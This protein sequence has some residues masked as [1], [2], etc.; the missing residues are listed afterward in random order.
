MNIKIFGCRFNKFCAQKWLNYLNK[1]DNYILIAS[2]AVTDNAKKKF[3]KEVKQQIKNW[4]KIYLTWCGAFY[5]NG[6][7]DNNWFYDT[8]KCLSDYK[9][10]ITL[11][12][13]FPENTNI[14][15]FDKKLYTKWFVIV[16][17]GC[18]NNCTFCITTK[19]RWNHK[20]RKIKDVINDI[21]KLY[22]LW[23]KEI[24]LT[25]I[26]LASWW[27]KTTHDYP[28]DIFPIYLKDILKNTDVPRIR[29]SSIWPEFITDNRFKIFENK[30]I[31]PYFHLSIQS[32]SD[33][34][35]KL[36]WRHYNKKLILD[37]LK[38]FYNLNKSVP[39]NIW[40]DII[41]W[42]PWE[43]DNDFKQT[44]EIASYITK[45]HVFSFS[46][47]KIWDTV[48]ASVLPDKINQNKKDKR[49]ERLNII[50]SK[51][52]EKLVNNTKWKKVNVL[53]EDNNKW[54]TDNYLKFECKRKIPK[55]EIIEVIF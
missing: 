24:V 43:T 13:E 27:L 31:L 40:A 30:R 52:Y 9:Q 23:V 32:W 7:V 16:Q 12:P 44:L 21:N 10:N 47:H 22:S 1:D 49:K 45:L 19:K 34:I 2:C 17:S 37:L 35:L 50:C 5:E 14:N 3:I 11:L 20:N 26:N 48:P 8:Y 39:V 15:Y 46:G 42:F 28:N 4:K 25:W 33:K 38:N 18:D 53:I 55:W 41:V 36:M 51:N 6:K 29:I 54:R